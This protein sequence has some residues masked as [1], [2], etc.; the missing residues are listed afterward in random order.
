MSA[1]FNAARWVDAS[2]RGGISWSLEADDHLWI[3]IPLIDSPA[4]E[5]WDRMRADLK[6]HHSSVL[7]ELRRRV[8]AGSWCLHASGNLAIDG[9]V[10]SRPAT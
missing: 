3:Y 9:P 8:G 10:M 7:T 5:I 2:L 6:L 4:Q 1:R